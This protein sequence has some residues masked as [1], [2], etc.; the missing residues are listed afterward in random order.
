MQMPC[1]LFY[2]AWHLFRRSNCADV[3]CQIC[4]LRSRFTLTSSASRRSGRAAQCWQRPRRGAGFR[5]D[6]RPVKLLAASG[7]TGGDAPV[8]RARS[9]PLDRA[10]MRRSLSEFQRNPL[11]ACDGLCNLNQITRAR[12]ICSLSPHRRS[13]RRCSNDRG[14]RGAFPP[15]I[16]SPRA[17]ALIHRFTAGF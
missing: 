14:F 12:S 6:N 7:I 15:F 8:L 13:A 9:A 16:A 17:P 3:Y 1:R 2:S 4:S 5:S 11:A 10:D